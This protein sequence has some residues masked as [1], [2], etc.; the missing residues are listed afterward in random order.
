MHSTNN[1]KGRTSITH[2]M[3]YSTPYRTQQQIVSRFGPTRNTRRNPTW[4]LG[5]GYHASDKARYVHANYRF[6]VDPRGDYHS[7]A[8]DADVHLDW[9]NVLQVLA[10]S[11]SQSTSCPICLD[12]PVAPRMARCGH[13]FCLP[14]IIRFMHSDDG[15]RPAGPEK[16]ARSKKCPICHDTFYTSEVRP[17]RWYDGHESGASLAVGADVVLRLIKRSAGSTLAMPR[18]GPNSVNKT[19]D[20]PWY[21]V[22]EVMDHAR[23][24]KGGEAYMVGQIDDDIAAIAAQEHTDDIMFGES[25]EWTSRAAQMLRMAKDQFK[26]L[27]NPPVERHKPEIS[28]AVNGQPAIADPPP[29]TSNKDSG[30]S[31]KESLLSIPLVDFKNPQQAE[32]QPEAYYFYQAMSHFYLAALDIRILKD[33]FK[34][35]D[36][37]PSSLL[38]RIERISAGHV[39]DEELRKR[40]KYLGHLPYGCEVGFL[41]CD[42]VD[43][44]PEEIIEKYSKDIDRRRKRNYEKDTREEKERILAE[45]AS[46]REYAALG[47]AGRQDYTIPESLAIENF[48]S[49][50]ATASSTSMDSHGGLAPSPNGIHRD[51]TSAFAPLASPGTSPNAVRTVWGTT[52]IPSSESEGWMLDSTEPRDDG[53]LHGWENDVMHPDERKLVSQVEATSL[54]LD[55]EAAMPNKSVGGNKGKKKGK[56]ITLMSTTARRGA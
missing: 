41:E 32:K 20:V 12:T 46:E 22:A 45:R 56:K 3:N 31:D 37:F 54:G 47:P 34:S 27:G 28:P 7:Q 55:V 23:I 36:A 52:A 48:Q 33:A 19:D 25:N 43:T 49:L 18:D 15:E 42:W 4:G 21:S 24:M 14:C 38:P 16:R 29:T 50:G 2:L 26:G 5:S 35:Y 17:V 40:M 6:I 13:I 44:V 1:R 9:Q 39:V 30:T 53:W 10:S 11:H 8:V 51:N